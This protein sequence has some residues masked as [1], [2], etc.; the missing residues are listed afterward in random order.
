MEMFIYAYTLWYNLYAGFPAER[1]KH[2][3]IS[4]ADKLGASLKI[5]IKIASF[6]EINF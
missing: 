6:E 1:H 4:N 2:L 3:K 5:I